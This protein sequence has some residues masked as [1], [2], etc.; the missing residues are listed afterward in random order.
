MTLKPPDKQGVQSGSSN[1]LQREVADR[2]TRRWEEARRKERR[3]A[4]MAAIRNWF[5]IFVLCGILGGGFYAWKTGI[6]EQWLNGS[7]PGAVPSTDRI[8]VQ[9]PHSEAPTQDAE[10]LPKAA[11]DT[12]ADVDPS[13]LYAEAVRSFTDVAFGRWKNAPASV[14]PDKSKVPLTFRCLIP[15]EQGKPLVLE[16]RTA[17]GAKMGIRR[18]SPRLGVVDFKLERFNRLVKK[19]PYLIVRDGCA[20]FAKSGADYLA[21]PFPFPAGDEINPSRMDLGALY[22]VMETL[23]TAKPKFRYAVKFEVKGESAP[24][25]VATV[26]FGESVPRKNFMEKLA[27]KY[28]LDVKSE[29]MA[30]DALLR[31]GRVR[32]TEL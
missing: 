31:T 28:G 29:A 30:L 32:I 10:Q 15:D 5:V 6:I 13:K 3:A 26:G 23:K 12:M 14:R 7:D 1:E 19:S 9:R 24:I 22:G 16:L 25:D 8:A 20:Y 18:F 17:P 4:R 11:V 2:V 21:G 27:A